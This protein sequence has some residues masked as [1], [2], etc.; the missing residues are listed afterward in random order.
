MSLPFDIS[1]CGIT[2]GNEACPLAARCA[3][4]LDPGH[5]TYQAYTAFPGG[6]D[7]Y[8]FIATEERGEGKQ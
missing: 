5:P 2:P 4:R 3:R 1:R 7:C 8:G 6:E